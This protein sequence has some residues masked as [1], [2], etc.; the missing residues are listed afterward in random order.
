VFEQDSGDAR[1]VETGTEAIAVR[2]ETLGHA[3][4]RCDCQFHSSGRTQ[5]AGWRALTDA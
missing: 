2:T 5:H 1:V 3:C 4:G